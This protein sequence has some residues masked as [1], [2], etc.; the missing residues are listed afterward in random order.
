MV[1]V[2]KNILLVDEDAAVREAL[3]RALTLENYRV[4]AAANAQEASQKALA[5]SIDAAVFDLDLHDPHRWQTVRGV[6][7][8]NPASRR[9]GMTSRRDRT[10]L[11]VAADLDALLFKPFDVSALLQELQEM[12]SGNWG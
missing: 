12:P 10:V 5:T 3:T 11:A 1:L 9:I 7:K 6:I 8:R 2:R 4:V